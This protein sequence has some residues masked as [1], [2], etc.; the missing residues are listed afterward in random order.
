MI[1]VF[2]VLFG[3]SKNHK[4]HWFLLYFLAFAPLSHAGDIKGS[5]SQMVEGYSAEVVAKTSLLGPETEAFFDRVHERLQLLPA[6]EPMREDASAQC[7]FD[8]DGDCDD[9][10]RIFFRSRIGIC[11]GHARYHPLA[12]S[13]ADGCITPEDESSLFITNSDKQSLPADHKVNPK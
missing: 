3:I 8:R 2:I 9:A 6:G 13:D 4:R 7:D 1:K 12:D 5:S 11:R 10:D